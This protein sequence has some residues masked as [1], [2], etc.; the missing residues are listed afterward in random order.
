MK[1]PWLGLREASDL[2]STKKYFWAVAAC[3]V[4]N[5]LTPNNLSNPNGRGRWKKL[6]KSS[7]VKSNTH[8]RSHSL[9]LTQGFCTA[10]HFFNPSQND[11]TT[12]ERSNS[13]NS[14]SN[15]KGAAASKSNADPLEIDLTS[16]FN[17][18]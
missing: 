4:C 6:K 18:T 16:F 2:Q 5:L 13:S 10:E 15:L 7:C 17:L 9:S 12:N 8:S 1:M 3:A 14:S 11:E